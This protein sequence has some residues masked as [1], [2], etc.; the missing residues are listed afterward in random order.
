MS[1]HMYLIVGILVIAFGTFF[2]YSMV[3]DDGGTTRSYGGG[4]G[5]FVG[6]GAGGHK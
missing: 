2:N 5:G 6:G 1:R 3:Y 4:A